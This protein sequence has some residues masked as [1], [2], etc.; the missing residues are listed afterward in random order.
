MVDGSTMRLRL[1]APLVLGGLLLVPAR[2]HAGYTDGDVPE[3]GNASTLGRHAV[4][5][6]LIGESGIGLTDHTEL[7]TF[8]LYDAVLFPNLQLEHRF[9]DGTLAASW[10]VGLGAGALP[11]VAGTALPLPGGIVGAA[12]VGVIGAAEEHAALHLSWRAARSITVSAT[13]GAWALEGGFAGVVAGAG[14]GGGG[15]GGTGA[16]VSGSSSRGGPM[17][18]VELAATLSPHD[19]LLV[20]VDGWAF[21]PYV[22]DGA[23]GLLYGR[24]TYTHVW[25]HFGLTLGVYGLADPPHFRT[26]RDAKVPLGP[27]ASIAWTWP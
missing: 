18:G 7:S 5:L 25:T 1:F 22:T 2:A 16:P 4:R 14:V 27:Y 13:A 12:G 20:A 8:L 10:S 6:S 26:V 15:G 3:G 23:S 21:K 19:A 9:M 24:A 11:I 17:A